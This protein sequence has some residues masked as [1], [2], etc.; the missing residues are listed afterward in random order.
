MSHR[1]LTALL[2]TPLLLC[3]RVD[4]GDPPPAAPAADAPALAPAKPWH[5]QLAHRNARYASLARVDDPAGDVH[6]AI[7]AHMNLNRVVDPLGD[8]E[9]VR[10]ARATKNLPPRA[11]ADAFVA[12][13]ADDLGD[14]GQLAMHKLTNERRHAETRRFR[15]V[16]GDRHELIAHQR[17]VKLKHRLHQENVIRHAGPFEQPGIIERRDDQ[18]EDAA[19]RDRAVLEER[20]AEWFLSR[21]GEDRGPAAAMSDEGELGAE[22]ELGELGDDTAI[23]DATE[24]G[25]ERLEEKLLENETEAQAEKAEG[26]GTG[27]P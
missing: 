19:E 24:M 8:M 22:G 21:D 17:D 1:V 12:R 25:E 15:D 23:D 7:I 5:A 14:D 18:S 9:Q 20:D 11:T 6:E 27:T 3:S 26:G 10:V 13:A 4:A 16:G 2:L